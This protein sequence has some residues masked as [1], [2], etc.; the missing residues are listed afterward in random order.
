[1][2]SGPS[3]ETPAEIRAAAA[4]GADAVGMS[5]VPETI[6]ARYFGLTVAGVSV[7]TNLAAGLSATALS[8]AQTKTE[9]DRAAERFERLVTRFAEGFA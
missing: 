9:A 8:H 6:L 5:T 1:L 7:I 2:Y 3:F 4:M